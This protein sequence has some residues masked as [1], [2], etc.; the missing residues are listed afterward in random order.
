MIKKIGSA[1]RQGVEVP[2]DVSWQ[3][4]EDSEFLSLLHKGVIIL[5]GLETTALQIRSELSIRLTIVKLPRHTWTGAIQCV[6]PVCWTQPVTILLLYRNSVMFQTSSLFALWEFI[7]KSTHKHRIV[8][9][10]TTSGVQFVTWQLVV[11]HHKITNTLIIICDQG[12][13]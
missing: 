3:Q 6:P 5:W 7:G 11:F 13:R 2:S 8:M 1:S 12:R 4:S 9:Y 10:A